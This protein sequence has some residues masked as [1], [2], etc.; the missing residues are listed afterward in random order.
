MQDVK[1]SLRKYLG[2][3]LDII[4]IEPE[5]KVIAVS[6][7][8]GIRGDMERD[9]EIGKRGYAV[10]MVRPESIID[11]ANIRD[12]LRGFSIR[13]KKECAKMAGMRSVVL[14]TYSL[15]SLE[16]SRKTLFGYALKGRNGE[17]GVLGNL[18]GHVV[19]RNS[20]IVPLP[21]FT[22]MKGFMDYW[23]LEYEA[24]E[25]METEKKSTQSG[26]AAGKK[27]GRG[28]GK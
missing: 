20:M 24:A 16:Q 25:M 14:V 17:E 10:K 21:S 1:P 28:K 11:E 15:K 2:R 6:S 4:I 18:G 3:A 5:K 19:G 23:G 8:T 22:K 12:V 9:R 13:K 26:T 27:K 7:D